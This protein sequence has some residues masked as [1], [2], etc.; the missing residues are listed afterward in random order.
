MFPSYVLHLSDRCTH[1][2]DIATSWSPMVNTSQGKKCLSVFCV[3]CT[4]NFFFPLF[5]QVF[6]YSLKAN[7][8]PSTETS[9]EVFC[10]ILKKF[11]V[12]S[13]C[14]YNLTRPFLLIDKWGDC[15]QSCQ[16]SLQYLFGRPLLNVSSKWWDD[17]GVEICSVIKLTITFLNCIW[18]YGREQQSLG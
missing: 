5:F 15:R 11:F 14:H 13:K 12:Q 2:G 3:T 8:F 17:L 6:T 10:K 4:L 18:Q 1:Y 9:S 16:C 7:T